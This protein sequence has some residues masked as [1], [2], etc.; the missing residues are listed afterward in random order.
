MRFFLPILLMLFAACAPQV[1]ETAIALLPIR[2]LNAMTLESAALGVGETQPWQFVGAAG[3]AVQITA[4]GMTLVLQGAQGDTLAQGV[5]VLTATLP[6]DGL[7]T[8]LVSAADAASYA[9]ELR[10]G[11]TASLTPTAAAATATPTSTA[12]L[13]PTPPYYAALG[14]LI[15]TLRSGETLNGTFALSEER[16]VYTFEG[17]AG[18]YIQVDAQPTSGSVDPRIALYAPDGSALA[19]DDNSAGDGRARLRNIR[20][21]AGG[22]YT[23]QVSGGGRGSYRVSLMSFTLPLAVTPTVITLPTSTAT[24]PLI[25]PTV[26]AVP[27]GERLRDHV[28]VIGSIERGGDFDRYPIEARAGEV[29]TIGARPFDEGSLRLRMEIY[30]PLGAQIASAES[31]NT[32]EALVGALLVPETGTYLIFVTGL[33]GGTG[34][35]LISYGEGF[36]RQ[37][38]WRGLTTADQLYAGEIGQRGLR[39][40]W[41]L[42]LNAGDVISAAVGA[43]D[44][45]FDPVLELAAPDGT[46]LASDD[47]SGGTLDALIGSAAVTVSGRYTLRVTAANALGAGSYNL[48]WRYINRTMTATPPPPSIL[49]MR[50][51]DSAAAESYQ[52]YPFQ[53]EAGMLVQIEVIAA[54]GD[55]LDP[56]AVLFGP[57]GEEVARGD[58]SP[59]DLNPRFTAE[60]PVNGTYTVRVNGYLSSGDFMLTV[61]ELLR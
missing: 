31:A 48:V 21:G 29:L 37:D 19:A 7:Y 6:T 43:L 1:E 14:D 13:S 30:D 42:D 23:V 44:L 34:D 47:N 10:Y 32:P 46:L 39:D 57:D 55:A 61:V 12:T 11:S 28:P 38:E 22:L 33:D 16:H 5:D 50:F 40:V 26:G 2:I 56:V 15:G 54:D 35:Y 3:E 59:G 58:D 17:S 18:Q 53:G 9:I 51:D 52:S 36:S 25:T 60:L 45:N 49:L 41:A 27:S 24:P 20:L 8:V 4:Q